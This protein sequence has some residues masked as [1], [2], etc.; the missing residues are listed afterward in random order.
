VG[1]FR[2]VSDGANK[3]VLDV[4]K[5]VYLSIRTVKVQRVTVVE[6]GMYNG[7]GDGVGCFEVKVGMNT[8]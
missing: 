8:A 7:S 6:F 1:I 3:G 5:S 2:C 4:L